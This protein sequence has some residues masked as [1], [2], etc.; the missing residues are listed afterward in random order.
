[1]LPMIAVGLQTPEMST[2]FGLDRLADRLAFLGKRREVKIAVFGLK[3]L[4]VNLRLFFTF[5]P[6]AGVLELADDITAVPNLAGVRRI[7]E[8][9]RRRAVSPCGNANPNVSGS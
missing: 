8:Q 3:Y 4:G 9:V 5:P 2:P 6:N 1:M 7:L